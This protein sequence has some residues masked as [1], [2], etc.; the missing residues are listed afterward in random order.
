MLN[1]L[2]RRVKMKKKSIVIVFGLFFAVTA[3][4]FG[5]S[6]NTVSTWL[7]QALSK[8]NQALRLVRST[9][10]ESNISEIQSKLGEIRDV[11]LKVENWTNQGNEFTSDQMEKF[12]KVMANINEVNQRII[13]LL[14]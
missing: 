8:S 6:S 9:D 1:I 3:L 2:P 10:A 7:N 14:L 12:L 4:V 11:I 5:Q 13:A